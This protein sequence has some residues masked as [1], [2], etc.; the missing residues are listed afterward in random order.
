MAG[1][2]TPHGQTAPTFRR[3][4]SPPTSKS[5]P[6]ASSSQSRISKAPP[7]TDARFRFPSW[8][9]FTTLLAQ[10]FHDPASKELHEKRMFNLRM[11]KG[12]AISYFQELEV[13]AKKANRRGETDARGL[14]V[15]AVRLGVPDSYT[16]AIANSGQHIP[17]TYNDWKRRIC[18]MYEERQKKWVFD[19]TIGA[20]SGSSKGIATTATSQPKAGGATS[21]TLAK[22]PSGSSATTG[23]RDSAGRWTT[24][25]GQGLPMSI[26]AQKLRNEGRCF[27][28]KEKGHMSKDCP[29][30]KEFQDIRS[31][32]VTNEP[33]TGSK[34]EE[35]AKDLHTGAHLSSTGRSHG[36]F[37][38][39]SSNP[40]CIIKCTNIFSEHS[41]ILHLRAPAFNVS[42]TTS[43]PV[44]ESQNRYAALSVEE[45][46]DNNDNDNDLPLKGCTDASPARAEAKAVKPAG[47][48]AESLPTRPLLMLGQTNANRPTSSL[49]GEIQSVNV[50][51]EKSPIIV[52][53]IDNA[54]LPRMTDGTKGSSKGSPD[55]VSYQHDQA[56]QTLG[57]TITTVDVESQLDGE[58]TARLP[59]QQR[60]KEDD[61]PTTNSKECEGCCSPRDGHKKA[62]AGNSE[63]QEETGNSA[64]AVQAQS[65]ALSRGSLLSTRDG[66]RSILPRNEPGSA[67]AQK[68]PAAGQEAAS[69]QAVQRGHPTTM[70]EVPDEEDDMA[71]QIWLAKERLPTIVKKGDEPSSA[72]PTKPNFAKWYKPFEV[73]WTLRAICEA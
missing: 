41:N 58:T 37:V 19:Q 47:H 35:I 36:L 24:H 50:T 21:S 54:S 30:K 67:K 4:S 42:S 17:V 8:S 45:C 52:T 48:E 70:I 57:S 43:N 20:R 23:G 62:R 61:E 1:C 71:Y 33:V 53:P 55:E 69:A 31:V 9:E 64:F 11:G 10:N 39:T 34:V 72:P 22:Q 32:Q 65:A 51:D 68:R 28:C 46:A 6:P 49:C 29:K 16:N 15:K 27:R 56:A 66:D 7:R 25:P 73:D 44:T 40:T 14:M 63:G 5:P 3:Q 60:V 18:I 26:D 59:G 12:P 38:G 13:E 2:K